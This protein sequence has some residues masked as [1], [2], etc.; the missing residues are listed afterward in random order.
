MDFFKLNF[1]SSLEKWKFFTLREPNSMRAKYSNSQVANG[2]DR[3]ES[4][5]HNYRI[6]LKFEL[7]EFDFIT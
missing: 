6:N 4:L 3:I 7:Q 5:K 2:F 1:P